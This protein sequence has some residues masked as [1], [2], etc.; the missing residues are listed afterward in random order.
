MTDRSPPADPVPDLGSLRPL[1][2]EEPSLASVL[3]RRDA[4]WAVPEAGRALALAGLAA[5]TD[6]RPVLVVT[7]TRAEADRLVA[8]VAAVL[9]CD[10]VALFPAWETLPFERVSPAV[11][12]MGQRLRVLHRLR[13]PA[14]APAVVVAP[15]RS[16]AQRLDPEAVV[17]PIVVGR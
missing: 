3:G 13:D 9:G 5:A 17:D 16:L 12:T 4:V 2:A 10:E 8:D 7:A 11:E 15:V 6:R 14:T 1:L